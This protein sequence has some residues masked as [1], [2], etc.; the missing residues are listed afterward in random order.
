MSNQLAPFV[1]KFEESTPIRIV[2]LDGE[3]WFVGKDVCQA[4]KYADTTNAM[5]LHC[6]GVAKY[7]PMFDNLG[8]RQEVRILSEADVMRL[9]CGSK[10]PAAQ[11]FEQWVFEE[12]L[13]SIRR[14]GRYAAPSAPA[15]PLPSSAPYFI[16]ETTYCGVPVISA[17]GLAELLNVTQ[18]QVHGAVSS[19]L[20][21]IVENVDI[22]RVKRRAE[23][24]AAGSLMVR[25]RRCHRL[26]FLTESGARKVRDYLAPSLPIPA[27]SAVPVRAAS[28]PEFPLPRLKPGVTPENLTFKIKWY[29]P[30]EMPRVE[31]T[32][33]F[34]LCRE[35]LRM[36]FDPSE[37]LSEFHAGRSAVAC[38]H[39]LRHILRRES[40]KL[41]EA[42]A[43]LD[44]T[45]RTVEIMKLQEEFFTYRPDGSHLENNAEFTRRTGIRV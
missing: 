8:R 30:S 4:L 20:S 35:L 24:L 36:G 21:G 12:V 9:I 7:H 45:S 10:L 22:F 28:V 13:P 17:P 14:T 11:K 5:K 31:N 39:L 6:R 42:A 2:T 1:F 23:L 44:D 29:S 43:A 19:D 32:A 40:E 3:Q 25:G 41:K 38:C 15:K 16:P 37:L 27:P 26:N 34:R 33:T 18:R